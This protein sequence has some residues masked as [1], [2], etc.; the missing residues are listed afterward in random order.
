MVEFYGSHDTAIVSKTKLT[1]YIHDPVAQDN[2]TKNGYQ[3]AVEEIRYVAEK[4]IEEIKT[5]HKIRPLSYTKAIESTKSN[6]MP[7]ASLKSNVQT[8]SMTKIIKSTKSA[9]TATTKTTKTAAAVTTTITQSPSILRSVQTRSVTRSM[10]TTTITQS[11]AS[12][13]SIQTRSVTRAM[14]RKRNE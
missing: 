10:K 7:S 12:S 4:R 14:K 3:K 6:I 1:Q 13:Q 9:A 5:K 11:P 8:R 2:D